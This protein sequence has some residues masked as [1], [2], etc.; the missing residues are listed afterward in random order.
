MLVGGGIVFV[1]LRIGSI[2]T[3]SAAV[4]AP[5][6]GAGAPS[7]SPTKRKRRGPA[8]PAAGDQPPPTLTEADLKTATEG[9]SL[10]VR[11]RSLDLATGEEPRDLLQDEIDNAIAGRSEELTACVVQARGAA[12]ISGRVVFGMVVGPSGN[13]SQARVEAPAYLIKNGLYRCARP[14]LLSVRYP[15]AGKDTVVRVSFDLE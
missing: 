4:E 5:D 15:A 3:E 9:D 8:V 12:Q 6:G 10:R 14:K 13:V 2:E 7:A 11:E 1:F